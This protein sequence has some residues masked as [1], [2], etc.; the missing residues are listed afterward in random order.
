MTEPTPQEPTA[1][2]D[3]VT[4][5]EPKVAN[6]QCEQAEPPDQ[7]QQPDTESQGEALKMEQEM[8]ITDSLEDGGEPVKVEGAPSPRRASCV[9]PWR[10]STDYYSALTPFGFT[11]AA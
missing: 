3:P 5:V 6:G 7:R 8:K 1:A 4:E 10:V 11:Q 2:Q 9:I